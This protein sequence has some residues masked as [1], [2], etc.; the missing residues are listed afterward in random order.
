MHTSQAQKSKGQ[1]WFYSQRLVLFHIKHRYC[2]PFSC[3]VNSLDTVVTE[4]TWTLDTNFIP[5]DTKRPRFHLSVVTPVFLYFHAHTET[6]YL[7]N[8]FGMNTYPEPCSWPSR[9]KHSFKPVLLIS[10]LSI[11]QT[12][13]QTKNPIA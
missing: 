4:H 12:D 9:L 11:G 13:R 2:I 8:N 5:S 3:Q 6:F 7:S 1:K 10:K